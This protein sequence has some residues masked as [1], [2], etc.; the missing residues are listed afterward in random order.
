MANTLYP[1][2]KEK[3]LQ[4]GINLLTDTLKVALVSSSYTPNLSTHEFLTD[5]GANRLNTDQTMA[6]RTVATGIFDAN[7]ITWSA[8]TAGS[9]AAYVVIYKDTGVAATSPLVALFDTI[10][11]FPVSTNGADIT[12]QWDNSASKILA[13]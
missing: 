7:D 6:G 11:N 9:T 3:I 5:L 4:A 13:L 8:V 12:C 2:A 1:K 10:T